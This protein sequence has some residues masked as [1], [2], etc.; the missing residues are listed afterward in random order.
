MYYNKC[1]TFYPLCFIYCLLI[2]E[3][4]SNKLFISFDCSSCEFCLPEFRP[5][6]AKILSALSVSFH[7]FKICVHVDVSICFFSFLK[8]V[9]T[10]F[11]TKQ[12]HIFRNYQKEQELARMSWKIKPEDLLLN[13]LGARGQYGSRF[14]LR[15]AAPV[16]RINGKT[17]FLYKINVVLPSFYFRLAECQRFY[18]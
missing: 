1:T 18:W 5:Y 13:H 4:D 2:R 11:A 6:C 3:R 10:T 15:S 14:S 8:Y 16:I 9:H 17:V 12:I 7:S